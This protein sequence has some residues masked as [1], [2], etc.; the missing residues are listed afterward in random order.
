[1]NNMTGDRKLLV[2][3]GAS[4]TAVLVAIAGVIAAGLIIV[5]TVMYFSRQPKAG[6]ANTGRSADDIAANS[7]SDNNQATADS[8]TG[9][10]SPNTGRTPGMPG[11]FDGIGTSSSS[12]SPAR[13]TRA[14]ESPGESGSTGSRAP[15][16]FGESGK[17]G[18]KPDET[19]ASKPADINPIDRILADQLFAK[20]KGQAEAADTIAMLQEAIVHNPEHMGACLLLAQ[21]T[22]DKKDVKLAVP[23]VSRLGKLVAT[24]PDGP[25]ELKATL[26]TLEGK[27]PALR[28]PLTR[29]ESDRPIYAVRYRTLADTQADTPLPSTVKAL[30]RAAGIDPKNTELATLR[31]KAAAAATAVKLPQPTEVSVPAE[32]KQSHE[33][34]SAEVAAGRFKEARE[35]LA[36]AVALDPDQC[37]YWCDLATCYQDLHEPAMAV[38]CLVRARDELADVADPTIAKQLDSRIRTSVERLDPKARQVAEADDDVVKEAALLIKRSRDIGDDAA[39]IE[40]TADLAAMGLALP[41]PPVAKAPPA[42]SPSK[43]ANT[44]P[45]SPTGSS[46]TPTGSSGTTPSTGTGSSS[47]STPT[48]V[49]PPRQPRPP[50]RRP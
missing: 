34:A 38:A 15:T 40:I 30:H 7:R 12:A 17:S 25:A 47:G 14:G 16:F 4:S 46:S 8:S 21:L 39:V 10:G 20:A 48:I 35:L 29:W 45:S 19:T 32:A 18:T 49:R 13:P 26:A 22:V 43:P 2:R 23:A 24:Q 9:R 27:L 37:D 11:F 33:K 3:R 42:A 31:N 6:S 1:M 28:E 50:R 36:S 44:E 5:A 41:T